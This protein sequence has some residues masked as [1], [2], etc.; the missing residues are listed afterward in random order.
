MTALR[1]A[2]MLALEALEDERYVKKYTHIVEAITALRTALEQPEQE[3]SQ[4]R[5]MVVVNLVREGINKH[6]AR[7]L[8]DHFAAT[9]PAAQ[10]EQRPVA[11]AVFEGW[12]A[13]D[14]YLPQ[15]YDEA[16]KMAGYKGDHA[17]VK[18]LYTTP[19]AAQPEQVDC[20]RCGHVCSQRKWI[21]LTDGE[22]KAT[23]EIQGMNDRI[24]FAR[25]IEARLKERN[26]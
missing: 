6:K 9:P 22:I 14:L 17:E 16:L 24:T 10:P 4:W 25:A 21:G 23:A 1:Q 2:A 7:D 26:T 18:P 19:P 12:N 11:W 13:H 15:E 20:P 5:D 8:A 3:P